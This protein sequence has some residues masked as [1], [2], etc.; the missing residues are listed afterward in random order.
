MTRLELSKCKSVKKKLRK[1]FLQYLEGL[2]S[3][4]LKSKLIVSN[5][6]SKNKYDSPNT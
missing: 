1:L 6:D 3:M 4:F 5:N 2:L